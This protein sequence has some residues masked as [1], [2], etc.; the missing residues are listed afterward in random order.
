MSEPIRVMVH[1]GAKIA[2]LD[3]IGSVNVIL[4]IYLFKFFSNCS[5]HQNSLLISTQYIPHLIFTSKHA[6]AHMI[7]L[8]IFSHGLFKH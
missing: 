5:I 6:S 8:L 2:G 4:K 1:I 3:V 7:R